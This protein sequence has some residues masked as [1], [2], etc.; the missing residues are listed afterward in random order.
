MRLLMVQYAG[1]YREAV[2]RFAEGKGETYYAHKYSV[3]DHALIGAN[4]V[5]TCDV[6]P[7]ATAVGIPARIIEKT[8]IN[9]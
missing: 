6:P 1:D 8:T 9:I 2:E 4:A 3:G 7:G 5:V